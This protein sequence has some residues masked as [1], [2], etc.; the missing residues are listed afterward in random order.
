MPS[1][2]SPADDETRDVVKKARFTPTEAASLERLA[3]ERGT[4]QSEV[5]RAGLRALLRVERRREHV[6][7]LVD[8]VSGEEPEKVRFELE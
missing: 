3:R 4:T 5:L 2:P 6:D 1:A 7:E 8:L